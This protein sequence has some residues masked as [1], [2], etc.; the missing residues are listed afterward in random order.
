[1][2]LMFEDGITNMKIIGVLVSKKGIII[3]SKDAWYVMYPIFHLLSS[4][5]C[6]W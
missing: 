4:L 3:N 5:M 2:Q 6:T 1:M